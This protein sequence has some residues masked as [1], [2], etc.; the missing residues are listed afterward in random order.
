MDEAGR[1]PLAGPVVAA[2]VILPHDVDF[3][4][5]NDSKLLS[6]S[7]RE[8]LFGVIADNALAVAVASRPPLGSTSKTSSRRRRTRWPKP[9]VCCRCG[10]TM[11]SLTATSAFPSSP[12]RRRS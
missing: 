2:A 9:S 10:R 7:E 5:V 1:G 11:S 4:G 8:R 6:A 3:P 12:R